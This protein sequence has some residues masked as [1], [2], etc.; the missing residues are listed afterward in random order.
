MLVLSVGNKYASAPGAFAPGDQKRVV[1]KFTNSKVFKGVATLT[2]D[3]R[4]DGKLDV[5]LSLAGRSSST[6]L[7]KE[8]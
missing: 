7:R 6:T 4:D 2:C 8:K 1:V 3:I 5:N